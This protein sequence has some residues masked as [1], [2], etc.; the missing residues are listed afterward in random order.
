M[1]FPGCE[2]PPKLAFMESIRIWANGKRDYSLGVRLY[3]VYGKDA[4]LKQLFAENIITDYKK[5]RLTEA[6]L[7]LLKPKVATKPSELHPA[8]IVPSSPTLIKEIKA[9]PEKGWSSTR[10]EIEDA[11]YNEWAPL[12][13]EL[14]FLTNTV[15]DTARRGEKDPELQIKACQMALRICDLDDECDDLYALRDTYKATGKLPDRWPY[16][17]PCF[18]PLLI[19]K[20]LANAE[21]YV[22]EYRSKLDKDGANEQYKA[23]LQKHEWFVSYYKKRLKIS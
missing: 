7:G 16:G 8:A 4:K 14:M 20:K 12:F 15:G 6:L 2:H 10:S 22:R 13:N 23:V 5:N 3:N 1:S 18:D 19:P 21:R 9:V 11:L 17:L